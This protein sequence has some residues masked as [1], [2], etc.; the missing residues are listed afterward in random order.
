[1]SS[2]DTMLDLLTPDIYRSFVKAIELRKW[3]NGQALTPGQLTT[4]MQAVI[5][6]EAKYLPE[7]ERTGYVPPKPGACN[8]GADTD[9]EQAVSWRQSIES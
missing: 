9:T 8:T 2:L 7:H 4:C 3:P 5:A 6:Y 1:M